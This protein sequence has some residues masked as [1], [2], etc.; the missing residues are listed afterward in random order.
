M[1]A[2]KA[3][4]EAKKITEAAA[5]AH[6]KAASPSPFKPAASPATN[7]KRGKTTYSFKLAKELVTQL[8]NTQDYGANKKIYRC[9]S[10]EK[11]VR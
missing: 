1:K 11:E 5:A 2:K 3:I 4:K 6:A 9:F 7:K 10:V 8:E